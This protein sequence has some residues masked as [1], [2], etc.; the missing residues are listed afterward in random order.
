MIFKQFFVKLWP[1]DS[2]SVCQGQMLLHKTYPFM[3]E[4]ICAKYGKN[5]FRTV[6]AVDWTQKYVPCFGS[7]ITNSWLNEL[8]AINLKSKAITSNVLSHATDHLCQIHCTC[9]MNR[10]HQEL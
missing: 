7:Y 2:E 10:I 9:D 1:N 3:L 8:E 5:P 4:I 6:C